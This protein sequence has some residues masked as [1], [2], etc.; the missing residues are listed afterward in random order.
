MKPIL[1]L[2][3]IVLGILFCTVWNVY[4]KEKNKIPAVQTWEYKSIVI[5]RPARSNADWSDWAEINGEQSMTL[6]LPVSV[7][8]KAKELGEQGWELVS[9]TPISNNAGG[10]GNSG[11][12]DLAGFTGQIMYW[13]KRPR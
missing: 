5:V 13:F 4:G 3:L 7:P 9:I 10:P 2:P 1:Y 11:Y 6:P 8:R 12:N